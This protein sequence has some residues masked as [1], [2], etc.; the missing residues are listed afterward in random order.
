MV[1]EG[2]DR[3]LELVTVDS[4]AGGRSAGESPTVAT[5]GYSNR[6]ATPR[7]PCLCPRLAQDGVARGSAD[8]LA[9]IFHG[10]SSR[11]AAKARLAR[12]PKRFGAGL[13]E[14]ILSGDERE[15]NAASRACSQSQQNGYEISG[16]AG[17][18]QLGGK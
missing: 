2:N 4:C 17:P 18:L 7:L 1:H 5:S 14:D 12:R 13:Y 6:P 11:D 9:R 3:V 16:L 8:E 10:C 15:D